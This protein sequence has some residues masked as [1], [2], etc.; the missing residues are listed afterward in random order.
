MN[1]NTIGLLLS[2]IQGDFFSIMVS[3]IEKD[4]REAGFDLLISINRDGNIK[5]EASSLPIGPQNT[6]GMIIFA[7][8]ASD[9]D[10]KY[11][12][13]NRYPVVLICRTAPDEINIPGV[14]VENLNATKNIIRHLVEIHNRRKIVFMRGLST[15]EDSI[16]R[17]RGYRAVLAEKNI[18]YNSSL[19]TTGNF[20]RE[21]AYNSIKKL[22]HKGTSFDAIFSGDDEAAI[23]AMA[24]LAD[25]GIDIPGEV[26]VAGFDDQPIAPYLN[27]PLTTIR[28][29]FGEV[30][31]KAVD[32][33]LKQINHQSV[34]KNTVIPSELIIRHSC[35][36]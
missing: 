15:H 9:N 24:A 30:G 17:E 23:G 16:T 20:D 27:P 34:D 18:P 21:C 4:T 11:F 13:F 1:T 25:E 14:C 7:D 8:C 10:L 5:S 12:Y 28:A 22:V 26:S 36:C 2:D 6:D 3:E 35:G 31:R 29:P 32:L 19:V 33:L